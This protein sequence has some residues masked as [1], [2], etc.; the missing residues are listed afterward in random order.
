MRGKDELSELIAGD[1]K[2]TAPLA[3][4]QIIAMELI[5]RPAEYATKDSALLGNLAFCL[6]A[7][8]IDGEHRLGTT[9]YRWRG[10]WERPGA[11]PVGLQPSWYAVVPMTLF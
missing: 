6:V 7:F 1:A 2:P 4:N 9:L 10:E 3:Q 8:E 5:W 11:Q